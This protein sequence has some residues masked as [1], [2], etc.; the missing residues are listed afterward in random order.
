MPESVRIQ[1]PQASGTK[2]EVQGRAGSV[3]KFKTRGKTNSRNVFP[4]DAQ[5]SVLI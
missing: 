4:R 2:W 5:S 3:Y 1:L